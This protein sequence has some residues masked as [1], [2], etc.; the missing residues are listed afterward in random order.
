MPPSLGSVSKAFIIQDDQI[1]PLT[2]EPGRIPNPLAMN[3]YV[4]GYDNS[5]HLNTLNVA[6]KTNL[7][8]YLERY[9]MLT[10]AINIK[11]AFII[12]IG[13][14]FQIT[15][16]QNFN[17][18]AVLLA[19]I[20]SIQNYFRIDKWQINQPIVIQD[21]SNIIAQVN[22]VQTVESVKFINKSGEAAN[23]SKY[24]YSISQA[25]Q[26]GIIYPSMDPS[27]FEIKFPNTDIQGQVTTY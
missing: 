13:I 21:I 11:D 23:Y 9:R 19:C 10:D 5:G 27:I 6:T 20:S 7:S 18:N 8:T 14:D 3:L 24:S 1:S 17:N 15:T 26:N 16:F 4:L 2:T 25:T 22:G 12:N